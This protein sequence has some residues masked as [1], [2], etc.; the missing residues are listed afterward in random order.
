MTAAPPVRPSRLG[1]AAAVFL[2]GAAFLAL[3]LARS[4]AI[5]PFAAPPPVAFGSGLGAGGAHCAAP[6]PT[7]SD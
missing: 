1:V 6:S 4:E 7:S 3:D 2:A 5:N